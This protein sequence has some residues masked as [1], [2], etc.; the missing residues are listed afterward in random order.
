[1]CM[2]V[3]GVM[4][5]HE[6]ISTTAFHTRRPLREDFDDDFNINVFPSQTQS[7]LL[8]ALHCTAKVLLPSVTT[9]A[10]MN[11]TI[12]DVFLFA[13]RFVASRSLVSS[14]TR[15]VASSSSS[16]SPRCRPS[17]CG[18]PFFV[19]YLSTAASTPPLYLTQKSLS[20]LSHFGITCSFGASFSA[21]VSSSPGRHTTPIWKS[22]NCFHAVVL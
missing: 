13:P 4:H 3:F 6:R 17:P 9:N 15:G 7:S 14:S 11:F 2:I 16:S 1:M 20:L 12:F 8:L 18:Y 21:K 19:K 5:M 22:F 10:R